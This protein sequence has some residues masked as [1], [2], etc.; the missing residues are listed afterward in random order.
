MVIMNN[1]HK[2]EYFLTPF[3]TTKFLPG[4][5]VWRLGGV[6][7]VDPDNELLYAQGVGQQ[8]VLPRLAVLGNS[9]LEFS[10]A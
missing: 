10:G 6:H 9:S 4:L 1:H 5:T 2:T 8:S 7:L 3:N